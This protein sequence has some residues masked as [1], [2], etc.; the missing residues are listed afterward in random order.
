MSTLQIKVRAKNLGGEHI[1]IDFWER[2][3]PSETWQKNGTIIM[4]P[5]L[6]VL[7]LCRISPSTKENPDIV[8]DKEIEFTVNWEVPS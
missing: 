8:G 1:H 6:A 2:K 5:V 7:F 3:L 4:S